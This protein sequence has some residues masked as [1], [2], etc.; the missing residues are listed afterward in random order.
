MGSE[1]CIR[2]RNKTL[3]AG[4]K[5][6]DHMEKT[7]KMSPWAK[8]AGNIESAEDFLS[9]YSKQ[10]YA[11]IWWITPAIDRVSEIRYRGKA[12]YDAVL[13]ILAVKRWELDKRQLPD[14]LEQLKA[15][16]YLKEL[17]DDPYGEGLLTYTRRNGDFVLYSL[18]D[19][20]DDD[21]GKQNPKDAWGRGK[22]GGDR[23]FWPVE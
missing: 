15:E 2:D 8:R 22:E 20:F 18:A 11:F 6:Y 16:G 5:L 21:A 4:N 13:T 23:V 14:S 9:A 3:A 17:P 10:R 1:M 12:F 7:I 19:D